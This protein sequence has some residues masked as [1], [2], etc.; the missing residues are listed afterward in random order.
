MVEQKKSRGKGT[1]FAVLEKEY[2]SSKIKQ[3]TKKLRPA[4]L[5]AGAYQKW[6]DRYS[7]DTDINNP[8]NPVYA[9]MPADKKEQLVLLNDNVSDLRFYDY[10]QNLVGR[11][12]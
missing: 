9:D 10:D 6:Q 1:D 5:K 4:I 12:T 2:E 8:D 7:W 11:Q 3:D